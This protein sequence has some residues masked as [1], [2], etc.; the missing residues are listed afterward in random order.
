MAHASACRLP[1]LTP[2]PLSRQRIDVCSA[3]L[4]L[5]TLVNRGFASELR[6]SARSGSVQA[7]ACIT[8]SARPSEIKNVRYLHPSVNKMRVMH[9]SVGRAPRVREAFRTRQKRCFCRWKCRLVGM[10]RPA[11]R[12]ADAVSSLR[13]AISLRLAGT[14]KKG[15]APCGT[16]PFCC[17]LAVSYLTKV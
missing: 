13:R 15:A 9:C 12:R 4:S 10:P 7:E 8:D 6:A 1:Y 11:W 3:C 5:R 17:N 14:T 2:S 16:A